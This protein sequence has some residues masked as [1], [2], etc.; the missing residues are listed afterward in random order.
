MTRQRNSQQQRDFDEV[1]ASGDLDEMF[2]AVD[3]AKVAAWEEA[4]AQS[5]RFE[6]GESGASCRCA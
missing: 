4:Q 6:F 5:A 3:T 2:A 1:L